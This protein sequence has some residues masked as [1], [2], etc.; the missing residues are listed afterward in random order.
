MK[1]K[2]EAEERRRFPL[3]LRLREALV[4]QEG[5]ITTVAAGTFA[6]RLRHIYLTFVLLLK[7]IIQRKTCQETPVKTVM[8]LAWEP[9]S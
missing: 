1:T 2:M 5:A 9:P 6:L 3:E 4:G 8:S 7:Q